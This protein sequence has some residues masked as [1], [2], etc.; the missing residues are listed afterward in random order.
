MLQIVMAKGSMV[1]DLASEIDRA[2]ATVVATERSEMRYFIGESVLISVVLYI[3]NKYLSSYIDALGLKD[4]ATQHATAT[5]E[6]LKRIRSKSV[7]AANQTEQNAILDESRKILKSHGMSSEIDKLAEQAVVDD[8]IE[9]GAGRAQARD[10][11]LRVTT[12]LR[13]GY[14]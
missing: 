11:A 14:L 9:L 7:T 2:L 5:T 8:L 1:E 6:F 4:L 13:S 12:V 10:T 3:L